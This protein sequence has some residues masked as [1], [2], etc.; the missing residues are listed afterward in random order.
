MVRCAT[1]FDKLFP[2]KCQGFLELRAL[3]DGIQTFVDPRDHDRIARFLDRY[4]EK[5]LVFGLASR[6]NQGDG[7]LANCVDLWALAID[8][9]FKTIPER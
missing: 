5:D 9:D 4:A 8:I 2:P 1:F 7:S 3:P 6:R